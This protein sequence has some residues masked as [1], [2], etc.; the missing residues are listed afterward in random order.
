MSKSVENYPE[1]SPEHFLRMLSGECGVDKSGKDDLDRRI[2][3]IKSTT[4]SDKEF[5]GSEDDLISST[6]DKFSSRFHPVV[7][8]RLIMYIEETSCLSGRATAN[9]LMKKIIG[10]NDLPNNGRAVLFE[11]YLRKYVNTLDNKKYTNFIKT[12]FLKTFLKLKHSMPLLYV[13]ICVLSGHFDK[14]R[15]VMTDIADDQRS[16]VDILTQIKTWLSVPSFKENEPFKKWLAD[17]AIT[18]NQKIKD[19]DYGPVLSEIC[20][21]NDIAI[22]ENVIPIDWMNE[23]VRKA[24]PHSLR[25]KEN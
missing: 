23:T 18:L 21:S 16:H 6:I 22:G 3:L 8:N 25:R 14:A 4:G 24:A 12:G 19:P 9:L 11:Y 17:V 20:K 5:A 2:E 10:T 15:S 1:I 7:C 13:E